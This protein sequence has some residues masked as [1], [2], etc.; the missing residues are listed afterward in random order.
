[1]IK[2]LGESMGPTVS[3]DEI[4][5]RWDSSRRASWGSRLLR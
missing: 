3:Q 5:S 1:M 2:A 4:K